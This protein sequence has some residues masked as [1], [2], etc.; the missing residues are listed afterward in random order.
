M[1]KIIAVINI[2]I[3]NSNKISQ[4]SLIDR[5][6]FFLYDQKHKW[7]I[8]QGDDNDVYYLHYYPGEEMI[9]QLASMEE[10]EWAHYNKLIT[11]SSKEL[12]TREAYE[13]LQ[14]LY[15]IVKEKSFGVDDAFDD[16]IK[17][18]EM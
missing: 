11:Y 16:I 14:E 6:C 2:M 9:D 8:T 13:S 17:S 1:S 3:S 7:S 4:V 12:K 5:E 18:D 15:R 10:I